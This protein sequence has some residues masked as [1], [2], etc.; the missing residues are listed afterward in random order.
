MTD[1]PQVET[2]ENTS[3]RRISRRG[4]L[5]VL[6]IGAGGLVVGAVVGGPTILREAQL[7]INQFFLNGALPTPD[8]PESPF[9]WF[10]IAPDNQA[11]LYMPKIE[12]GQGI[13][14]TLAQMAAEELE[15]DWETVSVKTPDTESAFNPELVFTFGSTSTIAL[16]EPTRKIGA[17][18]RQMLM[19]EAATQLGVDVSDLQAEN[20]VISSKG[21]SSLSK[22]YGAI[23]ADKSGEWVI[24]EEA[25]ALKS[26][27]E[28]KY[29][30][31]PLKRV[32]FY[33]KLTGRAVYGYD[34]KMPDMLYGA[35]ARPPRIGATLASASVGT[36]DQQPGV[37]EVVI[38][39]NFAGI[40]AE[41][42]SQAYAALEFLEL[43]WEGGTTASQQDIIDI[44][45]VPNEGGTLIQREG[46]VPANI[47]NGT[48]LTA[49]YRTAMVAHAHLEPQGALV[50]V[51]DNKVTVQVA[52]QH[53]GL[54][55]GA[56][57]EALDV[58]ENMV[59][60]IPTYLGGGFGRKLGF[61]VAVEAAYLS[62]AVGRPVHVGWNRPE[63]M[64]YGQFR[65]PVH[66]MLT[67]SI[68]NGE[69]SAVEHKLASGDV[70]FF[71]SGSM[72]PSF[73]EGILGADPLAAFGSQL[74][75]AFPNRQ[76]I[77]HRTKIPVPTAF[78][79]GL[80][81]FP[82]TFAV[83]TFVDE[84]ADATDMNP[85]DFR[86]KYLPQDDLGNRMKAVLEQVG[87]LSDWYGDIPEGRGRGLALSYDRGTV[88]ALVLECSI[89]DDK[90]RTHHAWCVA[91]PGLVV[92]PDGARAQV[93]GTIVMA[94][95]SVYHEAINIEDGMI[96]NENFN[97]Y[98]LIRMQDTPEI[99]VEFIN[100][101]DT[102]VG[103]MGEPV[104]GTIP[105]AVSNAIFNLNGE[106]IRE[107]PIQLA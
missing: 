60:I 67:A 38:L 97:T 6:G 30:G 95:S 102:P 44:V 88:S 68:E 55:K 99:T 105:A 92:N 76:V 54:T 86:L 33:E 19:T 53:P 62:R 75:Y 84:M 82:N 32:D 98:P 59:H 69:V 7:G 39:D 42:R 49:E 57:A 90:V 65:P 56:I 74:V 37:I 50:D 78:W 101:G 87:E 100:S 12:M 8:G 14:T 17:T 51:Q 11:T 89:E 25:V 28:F 21:D 18:M 91:D 31:Q 43:E 34:A 23:I 79:R 106:R 94:L 45:T 47:N 104:I 63:D 1:N 46:D 58:E 85:M 29:I 9:M 80:G 5:K 73:V 41:H 72:L 83:E 40:V 35:I 10:E 61:D 93:E 26:N 22:T 81:T 70:F 3:R 66:N 107:L 71:L 24:P 13:H 15:L 77:Y 64:R 16:Y 103:G 36:A 4:F 48:Q 27:D 20:S 96:T 52:T 2:T